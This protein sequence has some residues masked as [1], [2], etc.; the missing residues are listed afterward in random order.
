[1]GKLRA[2]RAIN[3]A[4]FDFVFDEQLAVGATHSAAYLRDLWHG[5]A[6]G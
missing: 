1:M 2:G 3:A 6:S 5:A 4:L